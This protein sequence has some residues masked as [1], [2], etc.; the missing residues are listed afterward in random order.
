M[1]STVIKTLKMRKKETKNCK[2]FRNRWKKK[3]T[4]LKTRSKRP[5][6]L[7]G[8]DDYDYPEPSGSD[9]PGSEEKNV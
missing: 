9:E 3:M 4:Q 5:V 8:W 2:I 6:K 7:T 1:S